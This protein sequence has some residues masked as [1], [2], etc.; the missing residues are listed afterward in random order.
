M[1]IS[2]RF[3]SGAK[4]RL[5]AATAALGLSAIT[6]NAAVSLVA[7][8]NDIT[9]GALN[10]K[11]GGTGWTAANWAG[12]NTLSVVAT[13]LTSPLYSLTQGG[14]A[15]HIQG[16][17]NGIRQDFR[18][19]AAPA[20]GELWFSFLAL[21]TSATTGAGL[22]FNAPTSTPFDNPGSAFLQ[23]VGTSLIYR[24]G[25]AADQTQLNKISL[26]DT[27]LIVGQMI[28]NGGGAADTI[29][30]WVNPNLVADPVITNYTPAISSSA[31]NFADSI[32]HIGAILH[33]TGGT[34]NS[35]HLDAIR[36]SDGNGNS[37]AAFQAVTGVPEPSVVALSV[38][39]AGVFSIRR[40]RR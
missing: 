15:Q 2:F 32:T 39:A 40:R 14:T 16:S 30:I 36:I 26:N 28:L 9:I 19:A 13:D 23:F 35:G 24:F 7:D 18:T 5:A 17:N 29:K 20:T 8:F 6:A 37:N 11:G 27:T 21:T 12:S 1:S 33:N 31:L 3:F 25:D 22:S 10:A 38:L 4:F 34:V